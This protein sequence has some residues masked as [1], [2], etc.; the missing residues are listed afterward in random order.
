MP[1]P[2]SNA[3]ARVRI[4]YTYLTYRLCADILVQTTAPEN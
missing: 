2:E 4:C 3:Q 1:R